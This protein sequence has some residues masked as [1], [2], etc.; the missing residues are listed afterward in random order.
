MKASKWSLPFSWIDLKL[1]EMNEVITVAQIIGDKQIAKSN[2]EELKSRTLS[3]MYFQEKEAFNLLKYGYRPEMEMLGRESPTK[4]Y[5]VKKA[6]QTVGEDQPIKINRINSQLQSKL[7]LRIDSRF[8][9]KYGFNG[10][11]SRP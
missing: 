8:Q 3:N 11:T 2:K 7:E 4:E 10:F 1:E 5:K 6:E 9:T